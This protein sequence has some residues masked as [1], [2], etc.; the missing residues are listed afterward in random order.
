MLQR[1][2]EIFSVNLF[3]QQCYICLDSP[4]KNVASDIDDWLPY[5]EDQLIESEKT[6]RLK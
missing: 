1:K 3:Q 6:Q 5:L 4:L 2:V